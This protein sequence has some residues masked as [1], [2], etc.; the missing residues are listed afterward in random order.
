MFCWQVIHMHEIMN[1]VYISNP[2][3]VTHDCQYRVR[4][5]DTCSDEI[6]EP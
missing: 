6:A 5:H 1:V 4:A 2:L 3:W